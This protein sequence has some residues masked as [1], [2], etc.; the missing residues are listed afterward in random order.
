MYRNKKAKKRKRGEPNYVAD[1]DKVFQYYIRLRDSM[2]GGYCRCISCGKLKP[3]DQ[4]QAGHFWSRK[5][6][7]VRWSENNVHGECVYCNIYNGD[8]LMGYRENLIKKIG[9]KAVDLLDVEHNMVRKWSDFEIVE[10]IKHYGLMVHQ[11]SASKSIPI[12]HD[13]V[14]IIKKYT[15][16]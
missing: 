8:H 11:L 6:M 2:P 9:Q 12:S 4:I 13:V 16:K 3:F 7:S 1:M 10:M 14:R 15:K 5:H